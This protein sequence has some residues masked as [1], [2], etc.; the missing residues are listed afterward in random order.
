M[1]AK[2]FSLA[3]EIET[4]PIIGNPKQYS[5]VVASQFHLYGISETVPN[6]VV[7]RFLRDAIQAKR[8]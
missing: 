5:L 2:T 4:D 1:E 7:Q 6:D 3:A 8:D